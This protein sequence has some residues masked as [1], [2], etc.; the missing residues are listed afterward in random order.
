MIARI[1]K[2]IE[3][4]DEGFTLIE[5]LV[6]M[7]II[8]I[9]AA[10]AI[11]TFL[12]QRTNG[13]NAAVKTDLSNVALG[14]ESAAVDQGGSY[15]AIVNGAVDAQVTVAGTPSVTNAGVTGVT[16]SPTAGVNIYV[17]QAGSATG[18]CLYGN[19]TNGG[20]YWT[21]S[22]AKGG[23]NPASFATAVLAKGAC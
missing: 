9:L 8:G 18:F 6:V 13:Y 15:A 22:K 17:G 21:Y 3:Q 10:I 19:N 7:I 11:P 14:V 2:S 20:A 12:N 5:L 16:Y 23:L 1:R 4:G